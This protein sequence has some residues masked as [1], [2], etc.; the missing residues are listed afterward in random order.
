MKSTIFDPVSPI[1]DFECA[2]QTV[3]PVRF[4]LVSN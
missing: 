2:S 3:T 1:P 4:T